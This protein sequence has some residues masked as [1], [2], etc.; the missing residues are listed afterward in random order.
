MPISY[1][2]TITCAAGNIQSTAGTNE[3]WAMGVSSDLVQTS[4]GSNCVV[5]A[6]VTGT[7][8]SALP[9]Q[10]CLTSDSSGDVINITLTP[11]TFS[12]S[13]DYQ[14]AQ[15]S[16]SGQAQI[17]FTDGSS[18]ICTYSLIASYRKVGV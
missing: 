3:T 17:T 8:A 1:S 11:Y 14:T 4:A 6:N 18:A 13:A 5:S 7:T 16:G 12:L 10:S 2:A 9:G 15:E